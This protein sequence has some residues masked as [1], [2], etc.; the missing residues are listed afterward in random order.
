M[1]K[2]KTLLFLSFF[3][4][5]STLSCTPEEP[6]VPSAAPPPASDTSTSSSPSLLESAS[7]SDSTVTEETDAFEEALGE[8]RDDLPLY[9]PDYDKA[10]L[11]ETT[12]GVPTLGVTWSIPDAQRAAVHYAVL[13][14]AH[15]YIVR[16]AEDCYIGQLRVT[17]Y[18]ILVAQV[19]A[20]DDA[21][22]LY[23]YV[24][25]DKLLSWPEDVVLEVLGE[26]IPKAEA[27]YYQYEKQ[28]YSS[29]TTVLL[30]VCYGCPS[31]I[32]ESYAVQLA[33]AGFTITDYYGTSLSDNGRVE[34]DFQYDM[35]NGLFLIQ[36]YRIDL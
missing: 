26:R 31:T 32:A 23:A 20:T 33:E 28:A 29:T 17:D 2:G 4:C 3:L 1:N 27:D 10:E 34:V 5:L 16:Q 25:Q 9:D 14:K 35:E 30:L 24:Y 15:G 11:V 12:A 36:T 13:L 18:Q 8:F 22:V 21:L 6:A 19:Q 7:P